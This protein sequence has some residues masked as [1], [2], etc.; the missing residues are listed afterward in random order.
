MIKTIFLIELVLIS[1]NLGIAV[2]TILAI[3]NT[4][5]LSIMSLKP[6]RKSAVLDQWTSCLADHSRAVVA[7]DICLSTVE[8]LRLRQSRL[9]RQGGHY[10]SLQSRARRFLS[11]NAVKHPLLHIPVFT[12][13]YLEQVTNAFEF[14]NIFWI[15]WL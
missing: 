11:L 12:P 4:D 9:S 6:F 1:M 7:T 14:S 13:L 15:L 10:Q 5:L 2:Y 3:G 8:P